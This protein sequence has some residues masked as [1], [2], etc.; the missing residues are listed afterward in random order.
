MHQI[1]VPPKLPPAVRHTP[2]AVGL[3]RIAPA[4]FPN[5]RDA[6][7]EPGDLRG[8]RVHLDLAVA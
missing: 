4:F 8:L 2:A 6:A 1:R 5:E 7:A 3:N